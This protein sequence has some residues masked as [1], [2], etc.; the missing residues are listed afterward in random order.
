MKIYSA[1]YNP[2]KEDD[3][4]IL[5]QGGFYLTFALIPSLMLLM[6]KEYIFA[7]IS[8]CIT[9]LIGYIQNWAYG[10]GIALNICYLISCGWFASDVCAYF[11]ERDGYKLK[12]VICA[13]SED[14]AE[15]I[16]YSRIKTYE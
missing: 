5:L 4:L 1:Y 7:F 14:E 10:V 6:R 12:D 8:L 16:Y 15:L 9:F 11:L 3:K 2:Q 13:K